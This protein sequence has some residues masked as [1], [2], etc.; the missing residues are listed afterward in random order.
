[1]E[2]R[3][4]AGGVAARARARAALGRAARACAW[5]ACAGA[6]LLVPAFGERALALASGSTGLPLPYYLWTAAM[7]LGLVAA[8][9]A[10]ALSGR[11]AAHRRAMC[12]GAAAALLAYLGVC[13]VWY[14]G[15]FELVRWVS[16]AKAPLR[17]LAW[18]LWGSLLPLWVIGEGASGASGAA[19]SPL[20]GAPGVDRL[21]E[22][23]R[24]VAE[25]LV[26]G[27]TLAQAGE[28]LGISA[29]SAATYRARACEK[30]GLG[31]LDELVGPE[32]GASSPAR[33]IDVSSTAA[34]PLA[35]MA[36]CA[37]AVLGCLR[38]G[39]A[40][41][42]PL[43]QFLCV[44][45]VVCALAVPWAALL[46][47]ARARGMRVRA[48][49]VTGRL[50]LVLCAL[51]ALGLVVGGGD[52]SYVVLPSGQAM[53]ALGVV[54]AP[55]YI[56]CVAWVAPHL[57]WPVEREA[58]ELDE[59]RCVLY[60][61]GRGAGELQARVLA[62]IALGRATPEICE[63]LHVARGTVNAYRAQGYDL[64]G[65]HSSRELAVLLARDVGCVPSAGK[66][67]PSADE[68]ETDE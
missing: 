4:T 49:L 32:L 43:D 9:L 67:R 60:L 63:D 31:S 22:R 16:W 25:L 20:A 13:A 48:R 42:P 64:V 62:Q 3:D 68:L 12:L 45:F 47:V 34:L 33:A 7:P 55:A 50:G 40:S 35:L 56:G 52:G 58:S 29:S 54:A 66:K 65:V 21:T 36:L 10:H 23:E 44:V 15:D 5:V 30:L 51:L 57:T 2:M 8:A 37:G 39:G 38:Q 19:A 6:L 61:R 28:A 53:V 11:L 1:M 24:E 46:A 41:E 26:T 27:S 59:E 17:Y 18:C 14:A